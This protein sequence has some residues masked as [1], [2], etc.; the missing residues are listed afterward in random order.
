MVNAERRK[1]VKQQPNFYLI[2]KQ[3]HLSSNE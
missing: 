1:F 2:F 3:N